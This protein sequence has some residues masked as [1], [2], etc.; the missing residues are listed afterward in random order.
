MHGKMQ[1][2]TRVVIELEDTSI[3]THQT[4]AKSISTGGMPIVL[5]KIWENKV[6]NFLNK[7]EGMLTK[8]ERERETY[9]WEFRLVSCHKYISATTSL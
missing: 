7:H 4:F 2:E 5:F 1:D 3:P 9:D 8:P 6:G